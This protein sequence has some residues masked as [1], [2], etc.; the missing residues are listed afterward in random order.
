MPA[1]SLYCF[2]AGKGAEKFAQQ[3]G[4]ANFGGETSYSY[5]RCS[6]VID[7]GIPYSRCK[8]G[9][10]LFLLL[11]FVFDE[12]GG[13]DLEVTA[14]VFEHRVLHVVDLSVIV[15]HSNSE[16]LVVWPPPNASR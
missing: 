2:P 9:P 3:R 13:A 4:L 1:S 5:D 8:A 7:H 10:N 11:F 14:S 6:P 12:A 16:G 15:L